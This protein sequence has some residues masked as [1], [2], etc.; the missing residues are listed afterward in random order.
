MKAIQS[1]VF[2]FAVLVVG[3]VIALVSASPPKYAT[4]L[5]ALKSF[6]H[7]KTRASTDVVVGMIGFYG[8]DQPRQWLVLAKDGRIADLMHEFVVSDGQVRA[9]RHFNRLPDQDL[10]DVPINRV[11][12][13]IDSDKAFQLA[14][15]L[16]AK[17]GIGYDSVHYQLR[18]RD[19]RSEPI[20]MLNL[21]DVR[22]VSVGVHYFSA[23]TG[24]LLRSEWHPDGPQE[25][26]GGPV[27]KIEKAIENVAKKVRGGRQAQRVPR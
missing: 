9:Q 25:V 3:G 6:E 20:W 13:R 11:D 14:E 5:A 10:P 4:A 2:I 21:I 16:A 18:C 27:M 8:Q 12:I 15:S 22:Q 23:V 1:K 26:A 24:E 17:A 7:S 19:L